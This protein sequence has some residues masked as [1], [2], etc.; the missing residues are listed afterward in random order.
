MQAPAVSGSHGYSELCL[1]ARNEERRLVELAKRRQYLRS[2]APFPYPGVEPPRRQVPEQGPAPTNDLARQSSSNQSGESNVRRCYNCGRPGHY[3]RNCLAQRMD[4]NGPGEHGGG[5][6]SRDQGGGR[7]GRGR[8][9]RHRGAQ[10]NGDQ[11]GG[12]RQVQTSVDPFP[13]QRSK[14]C[15][16]RTIHQPNM[17]DGGLVSTE[18]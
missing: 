6:S 12:T 18:V 1:A 11:G 13:L 3:A 4:N 14:L 5:W 9:G 17:P 8:G 15:W 16:R 10:P 7:P 2:G